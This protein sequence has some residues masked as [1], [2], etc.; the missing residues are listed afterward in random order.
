MGRNAP[1]LAPDDV[2]TRWMAIPNQLRT[3]VRGLSGERL[4]ARAGP[5]SLSIRQTVHHLVEANLIAS[6]IVIAALANSG[7]T[8]DWT[9]VMPGRPWMQRLGYDKAPVEPAVATL[10]ALVRHL[11]AILEAT[12]DGGQ[13]T[14]QLYDAP[15]APRYTKTVEQVLA[16]EVSHAR[17]HLD[18]LPPR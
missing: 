18:A 12:G 3:A 10:G 11:A 6:N 9:W 1:A 5:E 2:V 13:R 7:S 17:E 14:I 8:Y 16:D 4:D 15:G